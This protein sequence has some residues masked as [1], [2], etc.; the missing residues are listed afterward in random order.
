VDELVQSVSG[1]YT[2]LLIFFAVSGGI[3]AVYL[4]LNNI[5]LF[6]KIPKF[7]CSRTGSDEVFDCVEA[8]F[9]GNPDINF[10]VDRENPD[11]IYNWAEQIGL[12]CRPGWQVGLLGSSIFAGWCSTLL[13]MPAISNRIGRKIMFT[14]ALAANVVLFTVIMFTHS[15]I[16][17]MTSM[18]FLGFFNSAK[19]GV[20]WP[21]LLELVPMSSRAKHSAAFGVLGASWGVIG[22]FFFVFLTRNAYVFA[23]FGYVFQITT[24][25]LVLLLPESPVYLF[26]QGRVEEGR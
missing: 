26:F 8:N 1:I 14:Y 18:F 19:F 13:W 6:E 2:H 25:F 21:Y 22:A 12:I 24:F 4:V 20:G 17:M 16:F 3:I 10:W 9:C 5:S 15:F 7:K 23:A 11:T